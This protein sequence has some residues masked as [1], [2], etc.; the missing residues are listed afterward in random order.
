MRKTESVSEAADRLR[1][2]GLTRNKLVPSQTVIETCAEEDVCLVDQQHGVPQ[3][4]E[5][6]CMGESGLDD[7]RAGAQHP[8]ADQIQRDP[9]LLGNCERVSAP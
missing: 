9:S 3:P 1:G 7:F 2:R 6:Q 8:G 4:A 5:L